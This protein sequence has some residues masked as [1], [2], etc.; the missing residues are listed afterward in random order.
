MVQVNGATVITM[1][2]RVQPG[3][4]VR[5]DGQR[6]CTEKSICFEQPKG[7]VATHQGGKIKRSIQELLT[8]AA[9]YVVPAFGEMGRQATG[10]LFCTNDEDCEKMNSPG[11]A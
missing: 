8:Q 6:K 1:G 4:E 9:P 10:L 7:F 11:F 2:F 3:D 5:Y